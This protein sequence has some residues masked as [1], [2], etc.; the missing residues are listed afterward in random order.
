MCVTVSSRTLVVTSCGRAHL[1]AVSRCVLS[2]CCLF[3]L[4][5]VRGLRI[6]Q[7]LARC[8][9]ILPEIIGKLDS[10]WEMTVKKMS[11]IQRRASFD[12]G[13]MFMP[14]LHLAASEEICRY[15]QSRW[16]LVPVAVSGPALQNRVFIGLLLRVTLQTVG[17]PSLSCE[18]VALGPS[19]REGQALACLSI[20]II[21]M[22]PE[23][24]SK[25]R[26]SVRWIWVCSARDIVAA[27]KTTPL[28][29]GRG[30]VTQPLTRR[31]VALCL[32]RLWCGATFQLH[33]LRCERLTKGQ[34]SDG[35]KRFADILGPEILGRSE[36]YKSKDEFSL[37]SGRCPCSMP[38]LPS[39]HLIV[40]SSG[41]V[42]GE[43]ARWEV[44]SLCGCCA[45]KLREA[46]AQDNVFVSGRSS[47]RRVPFHAVWDPGTLKHLVDWRLR[48]SMRGSG[49][50]RD[51]C[52][53]HCET[54]CKFL[55]QPPAWR[56][57]RFAVV[58][59]RLNQHLFSGRIRYPCRQSS[60][61]RLFCTWFTQARK[62]CMVRMWLQPLKAVKTRTL[63]CTVPSTTASL[64]LLRCAASCNC[65]NTLLSQARWLCT[66]L[67]RSTLPASGNIGLDTII[68]AADH[69][70]I[71]SGDSSQIVFQSR[72]RDC[73][74]LCIRRP[75]PYLLQL[76]RAA[77]HSHECREACFWESHRT[78]CAPYHWRA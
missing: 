16:T 55:V 21:T 70:R 43:V 4:M 13:Y 56:N 75:L 27:M 1:P 46:E 26:S 61:G 42:V 45:Q 25:L 10:S 74:T 60:I 54:T 44:M 64:Y 71:L 2:R 51:D 9:W 28:L 8:V 32:P 49:R 3:R 59:K 37:A 38:C 57:L 62:N 24:N 78:E 31:I 7:S 58:E 39:S 15:S 19:V 50:F 76:S 14:P 29:V 53:E 48:N 12:S 5:P 77:V 52:R 34:H 68:V 35:G 40:L 30:D 11:S 33:Q 67:I 69:T 65:V 17:N 23:E 47:P 20:Q 6:L 36:L 73:S 66:L 72:Q 41:V 63:F 22:L 18:P